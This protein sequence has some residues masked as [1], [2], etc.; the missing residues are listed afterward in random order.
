MKHLAI[1]VALTSCSTNIGN[2][3]TPG[4]AGS[5][6]GSNNGA[7]PDGPVTCN[8]LPASQTDPCMLPAGTGVD[9]T[10]NSTFDTDA[11]V[12]TL[13][14]D[15]STIPVVVKN[16]TGPAGPLELIVA[17]TLKIEPGA[18]LRAKGTVAFG[19]IAFGSIDIGGII[20]VSSNATSLGAGEPTPYS[21]ND[22][23]CGAHS[24]GRS[25]TD[26]ASGG[27]GGGGAQG[28]GGVG[29][30]SPSTTGGVAGTAVTPIPLGPVAGCH[31]NRNG[32][33]ITMTV[34]GGEG[35]GAVYLA[36]TSIIVAAGGGVNA[37]GQGG[38]PN[39]LGTDSLAGGGGAGG[40][41]MLEA[42]AITIAGTLAAN[43]GG[44]GQGAIGAGS[45]SPGTDGQ[46]SGSAAPGGAG[47]TGALGGAGGAGATLVGGA[48]TTTAT[49]NSGGAG[50][51]G[52]AG[53]IIIHGTLTGTGVIS[54]PPST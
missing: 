54:P 46:L 23:A 43:G 31:G 14:S 25:P 48:G 53:F 2:S 12:L 4:D 7:S 15:G 36:G 8:T 47:G 35:G 13:D 44:G 40:T 10:A 9:I 3:G 42:S 39:M 11:G 27:G 18:T 51:G 20:D 33:V 1:L 24:G 41:I 45:A 37:G 32:N 49:G 16:V 21:T 6:D 34:F 50:G 30:S 22:V 38:E 5:G 29:G 52:G 19:S 28:A 17:T 26:D